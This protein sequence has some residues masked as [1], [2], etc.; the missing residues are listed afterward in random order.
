M[1][2]KGCGKEINSVIVVSKYVQT[3]FLEENRIVAYGLI[4]EIQETLKIVC[5]ECGYNLA[6]VVQE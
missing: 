4:E 2:C 1:K 5:G 3:G 6:E